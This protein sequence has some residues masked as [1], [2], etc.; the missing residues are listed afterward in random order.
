[1][2]VSI[3]YGKFIRLQI[4]SHVTAR[5]SGWLLVLLLDLLVESTFLSSKQD[6][7]HHTSKALTRADVSGVMAH[8]VHGL[9]IFL[10]NGGGLFLLDYHLGG[11]LGRHLLVR[12]STS[13]IGRERCCS[14]SCVGGFV[15]LVHHLFV[16]S[17]VF[18]SNG[19]LFHQH[20]LFDNEHNNE[21]IVDR[22]RRIKRGRRS[23]MRDD[24]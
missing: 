15:S 21:E 23:E 22:A 4:Y 12:S 1:M 20:L 2:C 19:G 3:V 6:T 11:L 8:D 10:L 9:I 16:Q 17:V 24:N 14:Q 5:S 18:S 13:R 7:R